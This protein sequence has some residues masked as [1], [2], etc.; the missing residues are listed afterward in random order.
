LTSG[1]I[2]IITATGDPTVSVSWEGTCT[3]AG[4]VE[5]GNGT[6]VATCTFAGLDEYH[7]VKVTFTQYKL[8]LPLILR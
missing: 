7:W 5:S 3:A 2:V 8:W 4:G 1:A 6:G